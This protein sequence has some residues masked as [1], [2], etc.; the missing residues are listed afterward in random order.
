MAAKFW[1]PE[2]TDI[3]PRDT[4]FVIQGR[5]HYGVVGRIFCHGNDG[6]HFIVGDLNNI[7]V[8][9]AQ[10]LCEQFPDLFRVLLR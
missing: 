9:G 7:D 5:E 2:E 6:P 8:L 3:N 10:A 4:A 1:F